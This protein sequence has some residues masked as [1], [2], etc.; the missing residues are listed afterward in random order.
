MKSWLRSLLLL[1]ILAGGL[2]LLYACTPARYFLEWP[3]GAELPSQD[4]AEAQGLSRANVQPPA[5]PDWSVSYVRTGTQGGQRVVFVHGSPGSAGD[6]DDYLADVPA[7]F[8][9]VAVDRPGFGFSTPLKALESLPLQAAALEPLICQPDG[10]KTIL[11]G[12]SLGGPIITRA[13]IDYADCIAGLVIVAGSLDPALEKVRFVQRLV[14]AP[15]LRYFLKDDWRIANDELIPYRKQLE[16]MAPRLSEIRA[17]IYIL[18]GT[19]DTLVPYGN[20]LFMQEAFSGSRQ[21][22]LLTFP[23][24]GHGIV[25]SGKKAVDEA[26]LAI[27]QLNRELT[28]Q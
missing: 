11:T 3:D 22:A 28:G 8:D 20:A 23:D 9:Y 10:Q 7:G 6:W 4:W 27:D 25:F 26:I 12:W 16:A 17:P 19:A 24:A 13:A 21:V 1:A 15:P 2:S 14:H 5:L 18:H